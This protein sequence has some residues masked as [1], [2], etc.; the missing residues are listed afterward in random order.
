MS[1]SNPIDKPLEFACNICGRLN[2]KARSAL[3]REAP[4]CDRCES[5]VRMRAMVYLV[6]RHLHGADVTLPDMKPTEH[7]GIGLSDWLGYSRPLAC[8]TRYQNTFYTR[9]PQLDITSPP[10]AQAG[11]LDFIISSDVFEH[12]VPPVDAA[13][14]GAAQLLKPG[15]LLAFSVPHGLDGE[16]VEHY[17]E[18]HD[19][20]IE[21]QG[22]HRSLINHTVDGRT[23]TYKD[24]CFHGGEGAT[25]EMRLFSLPSL[26]AMCLSAGLEEPQTL[27]EVPAFGIVWL[28]P[29]SRVMAIHKVR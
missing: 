2:R 3:G 6:T 5:S 26:N 13:F 19:F 7:V 22:I 1:D 18:L 14:R 27:A 28:E 4:S 21:G 9:R 25:L 24:L 17:P 23:Q 10:A 8:K 11:S 16:T 29:W 15:G 12:V 20:R